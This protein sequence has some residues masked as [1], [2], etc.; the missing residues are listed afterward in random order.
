M[1]TVRRM[2][3]PSF[4]TGVLACIAIL[5]LLFAV[6]VTTAH[7]TLAKAED[8]IDQKWSN[9][10]Q[11]YLQY[12]ELVPDIIDVMRDHVAPGDTTLD[13]LAQV[14]NDKSLDAY[15]SHTKITNLLQDL[16]HAVRDNQD[17]QSLGA[18]E[19]FVRL[20]QAE[21]S[22]S[23]AMGEYSAAV[24]KYNKD[25][26]ATPFQFNFERYVT[27]GSP[28]IYGLGPDGVDYS[29]AYPVEVYELNDGLVYDSPDP[30]PVQ[31]SNTSV[32]SSNPT[33][34]AS[35]ALVEVPKN[36]DRF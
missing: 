23:R 22:V 7:V 24:D 13:E 33:P 26:A 25:L 12:D 16:V 9:V 27:W 17:D 35:P 20:Y 3:W 15:S 6:F 1:N 18:N 19:V 21:Q 28:M 34:P 8:R 29:Y 5:M 36:P 11:V 10:E 14:V 31:D 32:P 4:I 2:D 30:L